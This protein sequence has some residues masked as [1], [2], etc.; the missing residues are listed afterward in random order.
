MAPAKRDF[1]DLNWTLIGSINRDSNADSLHAG[2]QLS[3]MAVDNGGFAHHI[4]NITGISL[5]ALYSLVFVEECCIAEKMSWAATRTTCRAEDVAYCLLG[6]FDINM[7]LLYG[8]GGE[9]AFVR[10]QEEILKHSVDRTIFAW[11]DSSAQQNTFQGL[12]AKS[13][14]C[15]GGRDRV[16]RYHAFSNI[17]EYDSS[18]VI[19]NRGISMNLPLMQIEGVINEYLACLRCGV[20]NSHCFIRLTWLGEGNQFARLCP[21]TLLVEECELS[22]AFEGST[23]VYIQQNITVPKG[24]QSHRISAFAFADAA[25]TNVL[26][27]N[28]WNPKTRCIELT[29]QIQQSPAPKRTIE[30]VIK[31]DDSL[32]EDW[33][34]FKLFIELDSSL[35]SGCEYR[36]ESEDADTTD[37]GKCLSKGDV[38]L[39]V[40]RSTKLFRGKLVQILSLDSDY[41]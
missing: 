15:F 19:T 33:G 6:L 18:V 37:N 34:S 3:H 39:S 28:F 8:E 40:G 17:T 32:L 1:F 20:G 24:Y 7:P 13:P 10:L 21:E 5:K 12:L 26:S 22:H 25:L 16:R 11:E 30:I 31:S 23:K 4:S 27:S 36:L 38:V 2:F 29:P 41:V 14:A 35:R 9:K